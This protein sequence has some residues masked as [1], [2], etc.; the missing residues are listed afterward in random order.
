MPD[1]TATLWHPTGEG[2][3][4]NEQSVGF[5]HRGVQ[6]LEERL[7]IEALL[8]ESAAVAPKSVWRQRRLQDKS[9]DI[10]LKDVHR[11]A[12]LRIVDTFVDCRHIC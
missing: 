11:G 4:H 12:N 8:S 5:G 10:K 9:L 2:R 7:Q 1:G 6:S 3:I